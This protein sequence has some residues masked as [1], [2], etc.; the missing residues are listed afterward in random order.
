MGEVNRHTYDNA[1]PG[2]GRGFASLETTYDAWTIGQ[3]ESIGVA[4]GWRCL[5]VGAGGPIG[6]W[7]AERVRPNGRLTVAG[8]ATDPLPEA[9]FDLVHARLVLFHVPDRDRALRRMVSALRPGG[10]LLVEDFDMLVLRDGG[11]GNMVRT[12]LADDVT[13][14]DVDL[15]ARVDAAFGAM[16][17]RHGVD[18]A[19]GRRLYGLLCAAGLTDVAAEGYLAIAP[20]GSPGA[21]QRLSLLERV[22]R[23][24]VAE[25]G[26]TGAELERACALLRNPGC[27]V[28]TPGV[29]VSARGRRIG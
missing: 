8:I 12:P 1:R 7:L 27:P 26:I 13:A 23:R 17:E 11:G 20:G 19:Y 5:E 28:L 10:W 14:D 24:L 18:L 2:A 9:P 16:L 21:G 15:L 3:L 4:E 25:G 29:L 6:R 22:G